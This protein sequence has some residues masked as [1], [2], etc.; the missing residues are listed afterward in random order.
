MQIIKRTPVDKKS[1]GVK[2]W[3][4]SGECHNQGHQQA[5][6]HGEEAGG[7]PKASGSEQF[8]GQEQERK[9]QTG[10]CKAQNGSENFQ[11]KDSGACHDQIQNKNDD[12]GNQ[13]N[14]HQFFHFLIA[15]LFCHRASLHFFSFLYHISI[16]KANLFCMRD[17]QKWQ[18]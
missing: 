11:P 16:R 3:I 9:R 15:V 8:F 5:H 17:P 1:T 14:S 2:C 7:H 4:H 12:I 13:R 18:Q 6:S 10:H